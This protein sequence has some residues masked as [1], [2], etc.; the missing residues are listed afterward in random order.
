MLQ[1]T[2]KN[3]LR[4]LDRTFYFVIILFAILLVNKLDVDFVIFCFIAFVIDTIPSLILHINYCF[5]NNGKKYLIN[6]N[7]IIQIIGDTKIEIF[8]EDIE[9]IVISKSA[10]INKGGIQILSME[11]YYYLKVQLKTGSNIYLTSLLSPQ[12]DKEIEKLKD[13][14]LIARN[15]FFCYIF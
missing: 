4:A 10:S 7:K 12:I 1:I 15:T 9:K 3:H 13:V 11:S 8:P 14:K 2:L 5:Y 6:T